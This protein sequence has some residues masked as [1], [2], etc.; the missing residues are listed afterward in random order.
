MLDIVN[1]VITNES[2]LVKLLGDFDSSFVGYV[3]VMQFD[4]AHVLTNDEFKRK[5]NGIPHN[6]FLVAAGF[7]PEKYNDSNHI[8]REVVLLRV[9]EPVP[10]PQDSDFVRTRIEHHQ[11][12]TV[13]EKYP[14]GV[15]DGHDPITANELQAGGLGCSV[16]GTF[17]I[18]DDGHLRLGSDIENFM[19]LSRMRAFK[20][21][22]DA[23]A[24]IVNHVNPE[25][26][27]KATEEAQK[28]GFHQIPSPIHIG[29]VRY[30]S[31]ARLHRGKGEAKVDV[32]VQPTDFLARRTAVFG[33]TRTGKSNTVKT[34]VSAVAL[35][36]MSDGIP[37]GQLIFDINGEYANANHQDDGSSIADVFP[38]QTVRYRAMETQGFEDLRT[39]F[40]TE[41]DQA[42]NLI[43][44]L[45]K[46]DTSPFTGQD[47][48]TFMTS[49]LE[50][51]DTDERSEHY[52]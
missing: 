39:N 14:V 47:L 29:T 2:P 18:D 25:I 46:Q 21:R 13:E 31:T 1:A 26:R 33:M 41:V 17:F 7:H 23:L 6:S 22:G 4:Q 45:F 5:V 36:A 44:A 43:Q 27:L 42:L 11:R 52:R 12:R 15:N 9:L 38:R 35:A 32:M 34:T 49:T 50:E 51:P 19:S 37:V 30:T 20:P 3:Y 24:T 40:Y 28:A 48:D 16:L 8:D 10:L